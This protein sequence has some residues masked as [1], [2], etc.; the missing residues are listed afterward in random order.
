MK[1][2]L[3]YSESI[4]INGEKEKERERENENYIPKYLFI[5]YHLVCL[6]STYYKGCAIT[7]KQA[8]E[9]DCHL[10]CFDR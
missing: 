9:S 5:K 10:Y 2:L 1:K 6:L 7:R 4:Q 3:S 8:S